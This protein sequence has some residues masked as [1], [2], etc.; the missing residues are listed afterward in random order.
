[1]LYHQRTVTVSSVDG[2]LTPGTMPAPAVDGNPPVTARAAGGVM[3]VPSPPS[4]SPWLLTSS[5][6]TPRITQPEPVRFF[7]AV[8]GVG[9]RVTEPVPG[10]IRR[11]GVHVHPVD[12]HGER[13]D[14]MACAGRW[15]RKGRSRRGSDRAAAAGQAREWSSASSA[16]PRATGS[17]QRHTTR[18]GIR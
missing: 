10:V 13:G 18:R 6:L 12:R 7:P 14:L 5:S 16:A 1:M 17:G 3:E 4:G 8:D 9:S 15:R 2:Y 11:A